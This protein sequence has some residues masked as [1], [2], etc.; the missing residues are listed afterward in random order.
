MLPDLLRQQL[1]IIGRRAHHEGRPK[2][3]TE[4]G[5]RL[6]DASLRAGHLGRVTG[7]EVVHCL[8]RIELRHRWQHPK[9]VCR[10]HEYVLGLSTQSRPGGVWNVRDRIRRPGV[11]RES[12]AIEIEPRPENM[13]YLIT[14]CQKLGHMM[15]I[16]Q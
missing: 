11:L 4:G 16:E 3:G 7:E 9:G 12:V 14:K 2:T 13:R 10:E 6:R 5:L 1:G 8:C 15:N